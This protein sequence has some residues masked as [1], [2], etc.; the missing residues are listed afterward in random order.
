MR[1]VLT[2]LVVL[3][4]LVPGFAHAQDSS[5]LVT[6]QEKSWGQDRRVFMDTEQSKIQEFVDSLLREDERAPADSGQ[7]DQSSKSGSKTDH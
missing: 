3:A 2:I 5:A 4:G 6:T 1:F 7:V